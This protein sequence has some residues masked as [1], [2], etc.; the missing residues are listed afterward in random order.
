[1]A[2]PALRVSPFFLILLGVTAVGGVFSVLG[3]SWGSSAAVIGGIFVLVVGGWAVSLCLHEYGHAIAAFRGGD[4]SVA[5]KG[6]LTLDIR[7]YTDVGY[8]FVLPLVIFLIGGLP[9]PGGAV[10]IQQ[11]ALRSKGWRSAVSFAGPLANL[12]LG[13]VLTVVVGAVPMP[14]PLAAGLSALALFQVVAFVLNMLPVPGLDGYGVLEP[15][16]SRPAQELGARVRPWAP[17]ALLA[18]LLFVPGVGG[19]FF[20]AAQSLYG[21]VGGNTSLAGAGYQALF[22]WRYL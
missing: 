1:M 17:L 4:R 16:L 9:L 21:A 15:Y 6:Y 13:I 12:L 22:F 20:S 14:I 19:A 5:A 10:W 11:G 8:S 7:R 18:V 3:A 2:S